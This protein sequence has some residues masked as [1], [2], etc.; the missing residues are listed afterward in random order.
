MSTPFPKRAELE[1]RQTSR[2]VRLLDTAWTRSRFYQE[3]WRR[4]G[5][6]RFELTTCADLGRLPTTTK[7]DLVADQESHP[8]YGTGLTAPLDHYVRLHQTSGTLGKPLRWLDTAESWETLLRC[9]R[10]TFELA[11]IGRGQRV[12]FPFSFGPF[13]GF[14]TAFE[15]ATSIGC[16]SIPGGGLSTGARLRLMLDLE[17][18]AICCTPTY[19]MHLAE[20][21]TTQG[22]DPREAGHVRTVI[23]AGEPGGSIPATRARI[24]SAYGAAVIDHSGLTEVGPLASESRSRPGGLYIF[25]EE[26]FVEILDL[27]TGEPTVPGR[28][29]ELVVTNLDRLG[30]PLIRYRTGDLVR[31]IRPTVADGFPFV[32]LEGG[33]LGRVDDMIPIR[34]NNFY[35]T[36]LEAVVR[37]FPEVVEYRVEVDTSSPLAELRVEIE[38]TAS[39]EPELTARLTQAIR[40]ELLFR[41]EVVLVPPGSLPRFEMKAN[42]IRRR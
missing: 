29:G 20:A 24:E 7:A 18:T 37:K 22:I 42:R 23:V 26:Y 25:E 28:V 14:W 31:P 32:W 6:S 21:A 4:A 10:W 33:I 11:G 16:L 27:G 12:F 35:P 39:A 38:P 36:S 30:S 34:G 5:A 15:A 8:P 41:A 13:L 19:A 17:A 9:W 40:D 3:H 1:R 2:L